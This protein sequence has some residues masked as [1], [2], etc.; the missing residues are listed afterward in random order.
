MFK[1]KQDL[2]YV[3]VKREGRKEGE[4]RQV[5]EKERDPKNTRIRHAIFISLH[6]HIAKHLYSDN[7]MTLSDPKGTLRKTSIIFK[8]YD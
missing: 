2:T 6:I 1:V 3:K 7:I 8:I 4:K 5:A